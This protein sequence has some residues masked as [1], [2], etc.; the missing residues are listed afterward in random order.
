MKSYVQKFSQKF[1]KSHLVKYQQLETVHHAVEQL[2]RY[3]KDAR[4]RFFLN[5]IESDETLKAKEKFLKKVKARLNMDLTPQE[6]LLCLET[7]IMDETELSVLL[8]QHDFGIWH[9]STFIQVMISIYEALIYVLSF[10]LYTP[11]SE[12]TQCYQSF[13]QGFFNQKNEASGELDACE[14]PSSNLKSDL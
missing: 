9:Y 7:L 6:K 2:E 3:L 8:Q 10:T 11:V 13:R 14:K 1:A 4:K 12:R 5:H